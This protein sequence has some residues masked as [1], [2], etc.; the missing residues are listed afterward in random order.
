VVPATTVAAERKTPPSPPELKPA[1]LKELLAL[2]PADLERCDIA[3]VNLLCAEGL[4]GSE[5]MNLESLL[6]TLD[7]WAKHVESETRKNFH[8]FAAKPREYENSLAYYRML[9]LA[10]VLQQDFGTFY[11]P[12][13]AAPQ[14][15]GTRESNDVFFGDSRDV[16]LNGLLSGK[17]FGTC[18]SLP[19]LYAAVAQRLGYPVKLATATGHFFVR[20]EEGGENLNVEATSV[21]FNTYPDEFYRHWPFPV[22]DADVRLYGLLRPRTKSELLGD[23][24]TI[25]A[26]TLTSMK[27]FNEAAETWALAARHLPETPALKRIV[28]HASERAT[29]GRNANRWDQLAEELIGLPVFFDDKLAYFQEQKVRVQQFM[30]QSTNLVAIEAAVK[31]LKDEIEAHRRDA[32][33]ASDAPNT[34]SPPQPRIIAVSPEFAEALAN[35]P[36]PQRV[37]IPAERVPI[38]Y[39]NEFPPELQK[40]LR[41]LNKEDQIVSE[42]NAFHVEDLNR[43]AQEASAAQLASI[44]REPR[45]L[46]RYV[47]PEYLPAEWREEMPEALRKR[48]ERVS[49]PEYVVGEIRQYQLDEQNKRWSEEAKKLLRPD[50]EPGVPP[51]QSGPPVQ[52][53]IIHQRTGTP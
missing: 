2:S 41:G 49:R 27:R 44:P 32:M 33:L 39:W 24:L 48:L 6:A 3:R 45:T 51:P 37:Q 50:F 30:N 53:Q 36:L 4:R 31:E 17:Y 8:R 46:P 52:I 9:M 29:D 11:S 19:V 47:R 15:K 34:A 13:R 25:R 26:T 7:V 28:Q 43:K 40:R 38:E 22:S 14:L 23:F 21:G 10:T 18:A 5:G 35:P 1:T 42:I 16:F 12:E 20:Y